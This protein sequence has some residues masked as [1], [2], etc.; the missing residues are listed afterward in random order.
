M[1]RTESARIAD[2]R[3]KSASRNQ[4]MPAL[5]AIL[6]AL[7]LTLILFPHDARAATSFSGTGPDSCFSTVPDGDP[8]YPDCIDSA[9]ASLTGPGLN[10]NNPLV[11][12]GPT[13][14]EQGPPAGITYIPTTGG[15]DFPSGDSGLC[16][17]CGVFDWYNT[18]GFI[19]SGL[20]S[21]CD[22]Y[23]DSLG[24]SNCEITISGALSGEGYVS[25]AVGP[26]PGDNSGGYLESSPGDPI[27]FTTAAATPFS[28][29]VYV[30]NGFNTV[31]LI[32][33]GCDSYDPAGDPYNPC[34]LDQNVNEPIT[35][36]YV[37]PSWSI[38]APGTPAVDI[39]ESTLIANAG[40]EPSSSAPEPGSLWL[41]ASPLLVLVCTG[42]LRRKRANWNLGCR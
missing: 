21:Y 7:V 31:D 37:D 30:A 6:P 11:E 33:T 40:I 34:Y 13:F 15:W 27:L 41:L 25:M 18:M 16:T 14:A 17:D 32:F 2:D 12:Q 29:T 28:M 9:W 42:I 4:S 22:T 19:V 20:P 23:A 8:Y 38:A 24:N 10:G 36:L 3:D 1:L 26:D 39:S 5:R 35:A